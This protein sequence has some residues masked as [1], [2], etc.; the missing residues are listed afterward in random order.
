MTVAF[1]GSRTIKQINGKYRGRDYPTDVLSFGY[2][3]ELDEDLPFLGDIVIAL[4]VACSHAKSRGISSDGEI[5][6]LLVHGIL[7]LLGHDHE[8]DSGEMARAQ[9]RLVRLK[10][11]TAAGPIFTGADTRRPTS[12]RRRSSRW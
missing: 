2:G 7:H 12:G 9:R 8:T 6:S 1:V 4:D 11:I 3:S 10:R 5:R